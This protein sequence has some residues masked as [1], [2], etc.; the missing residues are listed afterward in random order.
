MA[1]ASAM[2]GIR[3][4]LDGD[5]KPQRMAGP[6]HHIAGTLCGLPQ[7]LQEL[8]AEMV[9]DFAAQCP[10]NWVG[11]EER[12]YAEDRK[13]LA[14]QIAKEWA[15]EIHDGG[16][17]CNCV[18][19]WMAGLTPADQC[20]VANMVRRFLDL[21]DHPDELA[22]AKE[23][24]GRRDGAC[25]AVSKMMSGMTREE[26]REAEV[27]VRRFVQLCESSVGGERW[28]AIDRIKYDLAD[29][30]ESTLDWVAELIEKFARKMRSARSDRRQLRVVSLEVGPHGGDAG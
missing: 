10:R 27:M 24:H 29:I 28:T 3:V 9:D 15:A 1:T 8:A 16:F 17:A 19:N 2:N 12:E 25:R 20:R 18:A 21:C 5:L 23:P 11:N 30:D 14:H 26:R 22:R 6:A 4:R 13:A 7:E